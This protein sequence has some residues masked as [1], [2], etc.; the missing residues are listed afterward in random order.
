MKA[1]VLVAV[2]AL[3]VVLISEGAGSNI[4]FRQGGRVP[5]SSGGKT[6]SGTS[7]KSG[8]AANPDIVPEKFSASDFLFDFNTLPVITTGTGGTSRPGSVVQFPALEAYDI[9]ATVFTIE[10]GGVNQPHI[11]PRADE[12][13]FLVRG[14]IRACFSEENGGRVFCNDMIAGQATLFPR[15]NIHYQQNIGSEE[16]LFLSVLNSNN[17]GTSTVLARVL[18]LPLDPISSELNMPKS[19]VQDLINSLQPNLSPKGPG[20]ID[21]KIEFPQ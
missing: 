6:G 8:K 19:G 7:E 14:N 16:V 11:H 21:D 4:G 5:S 13:L 3:L 2:T 17:P 20:P 1:E 10:V 9:S 18:A 12:L 15:A